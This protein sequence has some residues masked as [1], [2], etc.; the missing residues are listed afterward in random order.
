M[1]RWFLSTPFAVEFEGSR[2]CVRPLRRPCYHKVEPASVLASVEVV[3]TR[4]FH[5]GSII[6]CSKSTKLI[7]TLFQLGRDTFITMPVYHLTKLSGNRVNP[8]PTRLCH[9]IMVIKSILA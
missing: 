2:P 5:H 3:G 7:L 6:S 9:T 8:I 1:R 4:S